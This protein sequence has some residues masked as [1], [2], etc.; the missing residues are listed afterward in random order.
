MLTGA[1]ATFMLHIAEARM[2]EGVPV[3][4]AKRWSTVAET[5]ESK[6]LIERHYIGANKIGACF[7]PTGAKI[8]AAIVN[9]T[10]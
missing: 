5:L 4:Y 7:T 3:P 1:D 2:P 6:G 8:F 10:K 9:S